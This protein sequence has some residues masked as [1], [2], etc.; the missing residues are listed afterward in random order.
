MTKVLYDFIAERF[1]RFA[2]N[3]FFDKVHLVQ[4]LHLAQ[5]FFRKSFIVLTTRPV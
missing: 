4:D 3:T 5:Y 1:H 2:R